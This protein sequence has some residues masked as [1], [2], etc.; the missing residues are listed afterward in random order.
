MILCCCHNH[1]NA[2]ACTYET[3]PATLTTDR[4][5]EI[6]SGRGSCTGDGCVCDTNST[7]GLP[8]WMGAGCNTLVVPG[9]RNVFATN[10]KYDANLDVPVGE[11]GSCI[12]DACSSGECNSPDCVS[13]ATHDIYTCQCTPGYEGYSCQDKILRHTDASLSEA[14]GPQG[15]Y[16]QGAKQNFTGQVFVTAV[17]QLLR[18]PVPVHGWILARCTLRRYQCRIPYR[19]SFPRATGDG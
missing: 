2:S 4:V 13:N 11:P 17:D 15:N 3:A 16:P 5:C 8:I 1:Q 6:C 9:C 12:Y 18:R 7:T 10:F 19:E 14:V